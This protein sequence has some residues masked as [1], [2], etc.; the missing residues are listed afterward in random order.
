MLNSADIAARLKSAL[1]TSGT[2]FFNIAERVFGSLGLGIPDD[3]D[4]QAYSIRVGADAAVRLQQSPDGRALMSTVLPLD[5]SQCAVDEL[6]A[7]LVLNQPG[8]AYPPL[9]VSIESDSGKIILWATFSLQ[10]LDREQ[11]ANTVERIA[12]RSQ[13]IIALLNSRLYRRGDQGE[14]G[15]L[16]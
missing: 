14:A 1:M 8:D 5:F 13:G 7:L 9:I 11:T 2:S 12:S 6:Q 3:P 16:S 4:A 15:R 10:D